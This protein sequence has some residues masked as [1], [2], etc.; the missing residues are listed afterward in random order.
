MTQLLKSLL[1]P[2]EF[3][4]ELYPFKFIYTCRSH[5]IPVALR[6]RPNRFLQFYLGNSRSATLAPGIWEPATSALDGF[7]SPLTLSPVG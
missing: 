3:Q 1:T 2:H 7:T 4:F 5:R 6:N